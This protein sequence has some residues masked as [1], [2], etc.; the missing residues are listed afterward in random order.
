MDAT[1]PCSLC[2]IHQLLW[3]KAFLYRE[4]AVMAHKLAYAKDRTK[5]P[6]HTVCSRLAMQV[7]DI[8]AAT[9]D[10]S[11]LFENLYDTVVRKMMSK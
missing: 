1:E 2:K 7:D 6:V 10:T 4:Q 9:R 8:D 3:L 11:H 5:Q